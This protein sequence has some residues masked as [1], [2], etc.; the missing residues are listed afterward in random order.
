M[1]YYKG[2]MIMFDK[3]NFMN[4]THIFVGLKEGVE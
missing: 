1:T 3:I 2:E 4:D